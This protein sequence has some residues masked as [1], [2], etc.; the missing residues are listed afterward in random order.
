[1]TFDQLAEEVAN[2]FPQDRRVGKSAIHDWWQKHGK[3]A[4]RPG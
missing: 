4:Y 2:H 1:M 3:K